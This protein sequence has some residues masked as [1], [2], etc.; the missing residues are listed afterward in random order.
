MM[1]PSGLKIILLRVLLCLLY[2][3]VSDHGPISINCLFLAVCYNVWWTILRTGLAVWAFMLSK[4][5]SL[6]HKICPYQ[7]LSLPENQF[8]CTPFKIRTL[9]GILSSMAFRMSTLKCITIYK[10]GLKLKVSTINK[11]AGRN[12]KQA[13]GCKKQQCFQTFFIWMSPNMICPPR[14]YD[15]NVYQEIEQHKKI[16]SNTNQCCRNFVL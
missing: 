1:H 8:F 4:A 13:S 7:T 11:C 6:S 10:W 5:K 15:P 12:V 3:K 9:F 2:V 14:S 16:P